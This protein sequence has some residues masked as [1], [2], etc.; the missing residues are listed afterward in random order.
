M[1]QAIDPCDE[2]TFEQALAQLEVI[3]RKLEE[4]QLGLSDALA[5]YEAGIGH[6]KRCYEAL[7]KA[8]RKIELLAGVDA[9]GNLV[10]R[11]FD[12]AELSLEEKAGTRSR[13][14]SAKPS[15][16][17]SSPPA[18]AGQDVDDSPGLF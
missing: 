17:A 10:T 13:R 12:D 15:K 14:R 18:P 2:P 3:V 8:E 5:Q 1:S 16:S 6:L 4:G 7:D 9:A 11:P